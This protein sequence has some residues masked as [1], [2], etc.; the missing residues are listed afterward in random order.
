LPWLPLPPLPEL[1]ELPLPLLPLCDGV[2]GGA[3]WT[4]AGAE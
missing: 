1:A 4:G 2:R 3:E